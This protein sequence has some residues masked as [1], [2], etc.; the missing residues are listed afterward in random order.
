MKHFAALLDTLT[1]NTWGMTVTLRDFTDLAMS[2]AIAIGAGAGGATQR[3]KSTARHEPNYDYKETYAY[4]LF[5][6]FSC[7]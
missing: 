6:L 3:G 7:T 4:I 1:E 2:S 5:F